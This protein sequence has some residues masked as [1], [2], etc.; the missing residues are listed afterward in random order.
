M[1][2]TNSEDEIAE[3]VDALLGSNNERFRNALQREIS[4]LTGLV[5]L[6]GNFLVQNTLDGLV[7]LRRDFNDDPLVVF[8]VEIPGNQLSHLPQSSEIE[9]RIFGTVV[10][11]TKEGHIQIRPLAIF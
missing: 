7:V 2:P 1:E 8:Q 5:F 9:L 11:R 3:E 4:S 6:Q 10:R